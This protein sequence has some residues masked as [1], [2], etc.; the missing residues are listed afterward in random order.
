M[1]GYSEVIL[2]LALVGKIP[3]A[4]PLMA[5]AY[6]APRRGQLGDSTFGVRLQA[7]RLSN[8]I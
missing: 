5:R 8:P 6:M 4:L 3:V 1:R 7:Y 2:I